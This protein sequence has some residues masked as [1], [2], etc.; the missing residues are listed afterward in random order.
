[1]HVKVPEAT[2]IF[3]RMIL[4][5]S[6]NS[7]RWKKLLASQAWEKRAPSPLLLRCAPEVAVFT[8]Q[9]FHR[10][11]EVCSARGW[12]K[13]R[14]RRAP[15]ANSYLSL[16]PPVARCPSG[17]EVRFMLHQMKATEKGLMSLPLR[18]LTRALFLFLF[19]ILRT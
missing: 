15:L 6:L 1:M 4:I 13:K 16:I 3:L 7:E 11:H 9:L 8:A 10:W 12:R 17:K 18:C 5:P 14:K 19:K 2:E